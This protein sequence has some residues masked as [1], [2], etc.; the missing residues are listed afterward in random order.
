ML[1][2]SS[3]TISDEKGDASRI[4]TPSV[5]L[6][7]RRKDAVHRSSVHFHEHDPI[8]LERDQDIF[9]RPELR[10]API[11]RLVVTTE[12]HND[13]LGPT[14]VNVLQMRV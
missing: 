14:S 4:E 1:S 2:Q 7:V 10:T 11:F 8:V 3:H 5:D 12:K 13:E 6:A 9:D